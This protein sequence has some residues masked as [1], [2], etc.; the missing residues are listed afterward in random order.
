[1]AINGNFSTKYTLVLIIPIIPDKKQQAIVTEINRPVLKSSDLDILNSIL[2][3][4]ETCVKVVKFHDELKVQKK[5][6][7]ILK[8]IFNY[9]LIIKNYFITMSSNRESDKLLCLKKEI[10]KI[11]KKFMRIINAISTQSMIILEKDFYDTITTKEQLEIILMGGINISLR[12]ELLQFYL[13]YN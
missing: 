9:H 12:T 10:N 7:R 3:V 5:I 8:I 13:I 6:M 4:L 2:K 1:M 11:I